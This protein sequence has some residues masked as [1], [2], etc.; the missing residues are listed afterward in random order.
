MNIFILAYIC[1][2][3]EKR[4]ERVLPGNWLSREWTLST[5]VVKNVWFYIY[6]YCLTPFSPPPLLPLTFV[7]IYYV[8]KSLTFSYNYTLDSKTVPD[9]NN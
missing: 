5:N 7:D 2:S 3:L 4:H 8:I 9:G 6:T 1:V